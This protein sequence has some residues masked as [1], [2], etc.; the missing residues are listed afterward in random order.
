MRNERGFTFVELLI[1][2]AILAF[3]IMTSASV[4]VNYTQQEKRSERSLQVK[5]ILL[6]ISSQISDV[7]SK[8]PYFKVGAQN[9]AYILCYD[10]NG[11]QQ[12][13]SA[14]EQV[15]LLTAASIPANTLLCTTQ[16]EFRITTA[17]TAN[18]ITWTAV[19]VQRDPATGQLRAYPP[20]I[21]SRKLGN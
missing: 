16:I 18:E 3:I 9:G 21:F 6:E 2:A 10:K 15:H 12:P 5:K 8:L 14:A 17:M 13:Y 11:V 7:R 20:Y 1:S 4:I 19:G